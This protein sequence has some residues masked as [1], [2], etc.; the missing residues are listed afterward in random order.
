MTDPR[1]VPAPRPLH[2]E[3]GQRRPFSSVAVEAV[4]GVER[5]GDAL[6]EQFA[7]ALKPH[8]VSPTQYNVLRIL[9]G[10]GPDGLATL[11]IGHRMVTREPD[12]PRLI[13]R[14]EKAGLVT[15]RRCTKDRR[16]VWCTLSEQGAALM[17]VLDP[18]AEE[19]PVQQLSALTE[20]EQRTLVTL[21]DRVRATLR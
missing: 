10:A 12:V 2:D 17:H 16:V 15:R 21:L 14:M 7:A 8:G 11:E 9:R 19:L 1:P 13:D 6:R 20:S 3:I 5:T 18:I 4:L